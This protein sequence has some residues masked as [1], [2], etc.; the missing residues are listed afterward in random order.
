MKVSNVAIILDNMNP[1]EF[2][3]FMY[4]RSKK[5]WQDLRMKN[6]FKKQQQI[7]R[8]KKLIKMANFK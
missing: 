4:K 1:F 2:W 3:V 6:L 8:V 5:R 7:L